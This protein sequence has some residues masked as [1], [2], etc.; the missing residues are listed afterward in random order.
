MTDGFSG[1]VEL[2]TS[3]ERAWAVIEDP[4]A[5]G[6][7]LPDC[8]LVVPDGSGGLNVVVAVRQMFMTVRV[9]IHVTWHDLDR[10]RHL[11]LELDGRPRGI[12]GALRLS[13]PIDLEPTPA[14]SR[15]L[16]RATL[17]LE[18]TLGSFRRQVGEGLQAQ[19]D[20]LIRAVEHEA[21]AAG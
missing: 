8:E 11:R 7:I 10:P 19:L 1:T 14:G 13:V 12:G 15:V 4:A 9:D 21:A 6:R 17:E 18:G 3:P 2:A 20:R 16:Y 5:L